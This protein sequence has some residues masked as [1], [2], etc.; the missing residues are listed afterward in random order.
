MSKRV[1]NRSTEMKEAI[2]MHIAN[3]FLNQSDLKE[4]MNIANNT[5]IPR[6]H[7][8]SNRDEVGSTLHKKLCNNAI[9]ACPWAIAK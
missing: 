1:F 9:I 7:E 6:Q 5:L 3:P 8:I 2:E 4:I